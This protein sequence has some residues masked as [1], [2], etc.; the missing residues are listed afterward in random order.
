MEDT[1]VLTASRHC[2]VLAVFVAIAAVVGELKLKRRPMFF[3]ERT[4]EQKYV[5]TW[6]KREQTRSD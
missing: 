5:L 2:L 1:S 4:L 6:N 3:G